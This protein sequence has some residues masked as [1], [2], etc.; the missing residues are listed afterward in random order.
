ML[1]IPCAVFVVLVHTCSEFLNIPHGGQS[2]H[3]TKNK[4]KNKEFLVTGVY[5]CLVGVFLIPS[6]IGGWVPYE[7]HQ[8][9]NQ[10]W[11]WNAQ[12]DIFNGVVCKSVLFSDMFPEN[13]QL[14]T[15]TKATNTPSNPLD[16]VC[17]SRL[18][19][20]HSSQNFQ[21]CEAE[22][23]LST[24]GMDL[25]CMAD[26][27]AGGLE[28]PI[29]KSFE[30]PPRKLTWQWNITIFSR[31][32]ILKWLVFHCHVCFPGCIVYTSILLEWHDSLITIFLRSII[33]SHFNG[34]ITSWRH[35]FGIFVSHCQKAS[36]IQGC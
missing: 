8:A 3:T 19:L 6:V 28:D 4:D 33:T 7:S 14:N 17:V 13:Q 35:F 30:I 31:R 1:K 2:Y 20:A 34:M 12:G 18:Q 32:C 9:P 15:G 26:L 25:S 16:V 27:E 23:L 36:Q 29:F 11:I 21:P 22:R 10:Q 5:Q 24:C